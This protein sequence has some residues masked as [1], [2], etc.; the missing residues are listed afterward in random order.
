MT[1]YYNEDTLDIL[2]FVDT[3]NGGFKQSHAPA[4]NVA[5]VEYPLNDTYITLERDEDGVVF[6]TKPDIVSNIWMYYDVDATK[7]LNIYDCG[8][9][10]HAN[11]YPQSNA[12]NVGH[13]QL[14]LGVRTE[15]LDIR[16]DANGNIETFTNKNRDMYYWAISDWDVIRTK[17]N[18]LLAAC[19]WTQV[20]DSPLS[21]EKKQEWVTYREQLRDITSTFQKPSDVLWPV[22][23]L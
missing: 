2:N 1:L 18:K 13:M 21:T 10:D 11:A 7:I 15:T 17:R 9:V 22:V 8:I 12:E 14:P 19:D 16:I 4:S 3:E 23:P 5:S 6:V 20:P